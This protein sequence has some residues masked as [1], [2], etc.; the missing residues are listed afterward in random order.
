MSNLLTG[1]DKLIADIAGP[2]VFGDGTLTRVTG[3]VSDGR[4]GFTE[5]RTQVACKALVTEYSAFLKAQLGLT[6]A[7]RK[8]M[9]LGYGLSPPPAQGDVVG[10]AGGWWI[11]E[12]VV[13]DPAAATF[14]C[15]AKPT[16]QPQTTSV[17][18]VSGAASAVADAGTP[19]LRLV[20]NN[21][22]SAVGNTGTPAVLVAVSGEAAAVADAGAGI[23]RS[24]PVAAAASAVAEAG[25]GVEIS[26]EFNAA[27]IAVAN[28]GGPT[29]AVSVAAVASA[30]ADAGT[31]VRGVRITGDATALADAGTPTRTVFVSGAAEALAEAG[32]GVEVEDTGGPVT[33]DSTAI[34]ADNTAITADAA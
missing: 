31:V 15:Q 27:A 6:A 19:R 12:E 21:P 18:T 3:R 16:T 28:V 26:G 10:V 13:R 1:L 5:T 17:V 34:T 23:V 29:V 11:V 7:Q 20:V 25:D 24:V 32:D 2:L 8:I 33:A 9:V 30:A 4:G 22:A 14:E